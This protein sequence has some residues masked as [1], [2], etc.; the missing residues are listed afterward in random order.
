MIRNID[1]IDSQGI[2]AFYSAK[3]GTDIINGK[4][5]PGGTMPSVKERFISYAKINTQSILERGGVVFPSSAIQFDLARK[6]ENEL[7]EIGLEDISLDEN[8][9]LMAT[10]PSNTDKDIPV[11]GFIA[12]LDTS[13]DSNGANVNPQIIEKYDGGEI[14]LNKDLDIRMSPAEFPELK[15]YIGQELITTDGT[16]LLGADD[17]AGVAAIMSAMEHL[18]DHPEIKHGKVRIAFTPDEEIGHGADRFDV[19][20]FGAEYAYTVDGGEIGEL[21]YETFNAAQAEVTIAGRGVHPGSAKNKMINAIKVGMQLDS[22]LPANE[23]P[24]YTEGREGFIHLL[25]FSGN[26]ESVRM[27]YIIR[28]HDRKLWEKR[29]QAL[30]DAAEFL[31]KHYGEGRIAVKMVIQYYN[32]REKIEPVFHIVETAKQAY[33]SLGIKPIM[34]PVRGGTDG[35]RLSFMGLPCPNIFTGSFNNH[36]KYETLPTHSLERSVEV[37]LKI[38]EL[39]GKQ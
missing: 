11:I 15:K 18:V 34:V 27:L 37:V 35:S 29:K 20:K 24:E 38:I 21:E 28:D 26:V 25:S 39:I 12:H 22:M 5:T 33:S 7:H 16:S 31:N 23:R 3:V 13:P 6:L 32:M 9:Y 10:L 2:V 1:R 30:L 19:Q 14:V 36:G 8:C 4:P 17:K